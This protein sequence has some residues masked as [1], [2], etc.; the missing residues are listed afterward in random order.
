MKKHCETHDASGDADLF[1]E[2]KAEQA[3]TCCNTVLVGD[4]TDLL[5]LLCYHWSLESRDL[6]FSPE[7]KKNK[8]SLAY[9]TSRLWSN[10]MGRTYASTSSFCMQSLGAIQH[11]ASMGLE[12]E[13]P[14]INTK[15]TARSASRQM[16]CIHIKLQCTMLYIYYVQEIE[17]WSQWSSSTME[18]RLTLW[19]TSGINGSGRRSHQVQLMF[20]HIPYHH[21]QDQQIS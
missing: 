5:V 14:S 7:P 20:I 6:F 21:H 8:N 2:Q 15:R 11:L 18:D 19:T 17:H 12:R 9:R 13:L 3:A 16:C 1:I 4:D 10:G